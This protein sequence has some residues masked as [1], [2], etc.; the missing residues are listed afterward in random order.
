MASLNTPRKAQ[1]PQQGGIPP[2]VFEPSN[3]LRTHQ[4][5]PAAHISAELALRRSVCSCLLWEDTFYES[6]RDIATRIS[7]LAAQV[8]PKIV[9]DLAYDARTHFNLRHVPLLL[10]SVLARTGAGSR[11]V[12]DTIADTIQ[13]A[14]ELS[15]FLAVYAKVNGVEPKAL[16]KKL[17]AQVKKGLATAFQKFDR[18]QL[19]KYFSP[20]AESG[21]PIKARDV[22]FMAHPRPKNDE[23]A[24]LW[25]QLVAGEVKSADTWEVA[26]SAGHDKKETFE[27]QIREHKLGY[28][29]LLRN[30][31]NMAEAGVDPSLVQ[32]AVIARHGARRVLPFRYVAAARACPQMAP[33]IDQA[34]S[35]AIGEM[36]A[37]QGKTVILVDVSG[38]MDSKI[39]G[40]SDLTRM[41]AAATLASVI[42]GDLRVFTFSNGLVE[43]PP[44]R[45]LSGIDTVIR[46]QP[47]GGTDLGQAIATLSGGTRDFSLKA[48]RGQPRVEM[49]RLI[50]VTDEQSH[51]HVGAANAKHAY[52]INVASARN[53]VGY[54]ENWVHLDGFSE[55]VLRFIHEFEAINIQ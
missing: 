6:G 43:V 36:P 52:M 34:L 22:M 2:Q 9:A 41:D 26:L 11:L 39:S 7:E 28:M 35:E 23:Q 17:S 33:I 53:G 30:L 27:R 19:A 46:S 55:Q 3:T 47:H 15:E 44:H 48:I 5:A 12:G 13:R 4:G 49:D 31:R 40:K 24:Q 14:D 37:L 50:V 38:S 10:C 54:G 16:K 20:S 21:Q 8:A 29:A 32:Q 25:K 51:D 1:L 42:H 45:G 18:Y